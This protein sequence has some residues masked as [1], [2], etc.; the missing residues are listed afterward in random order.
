ML[1]AMAFADRLKLSRKAA[2]VTQQQL[3]E[4]CGLTTAAVSKWEQG[5]TDSV[6][7]ANL[8]CVADF[9]RVDPRWLATGD[10]GP[11]KPSTALD[12]IVRGLE[13]LPAEQQEA[14]RSIIRSMQK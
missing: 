5:L 7:A 2:G 8:Y 9:L 14:V 1:D 12:E 6:L 13:Q 3:A 10:G 11:V 4:A